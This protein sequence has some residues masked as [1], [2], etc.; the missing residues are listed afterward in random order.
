MAVQSSLG[1][2]LVADVYVYALQ[3]SE[4]SIL[5]IPSISPLQVVL[6]SSFFILLVTLIASIASTQLVTQLVSMWE[7]KVNRTHVY[8]R[9][10]QFV[11]VQ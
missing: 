1:E 2:H 5:R 10:K 3:F 7:V 8:E 6:L 11:V 9:Q 4:P